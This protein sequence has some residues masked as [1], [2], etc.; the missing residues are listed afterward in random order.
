[1]TDNHIHDWQETSSGGTHFSNGEVW[2]D[3]RDYLWCPLCGAE[4][5]QLPA[6]VVLDEIV[7][8]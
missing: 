8:F 4:C 1:M 6:D 3:T 7:E 2:D 5:D